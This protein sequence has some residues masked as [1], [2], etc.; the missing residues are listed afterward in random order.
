MQ[1]L[2]Y[3]REHK[4]LLESVRKGSPAK[5][6][7]YLGSSAVVNPL[8]QE[9][10]GALREAT[11]GDL[12]R[13]EGEELT[14]ESLVEQLES[15]SLFAKVKI[16]WVRE[17]NQA[18]KAL[19]RPIDQVW[20]DV[21]EG[22]FPSTILVVTASSLSPSSVL[23]KSVKGCGEVI[24]TGF[25]PKGSRRLPFVKSYIRESLARYGSSIEPGAVDLLLEFTGTG[26]LHSVNQEISKLAAMAEGGQVTS[27]MV[28]E[29]VIQ[30]RSEH[31]Y[32]LTSA[33]GA[34]DK[35]LP[36]VLSSLRRL[37]DQGLPPVVLLRTIANFLERVLVVKA[38]VELLEMEGVP[39]A[40]GFDLFK[41]RCLG[42]LKEILKEEGCETVIKE[43]KPYGIFKLA[44]A[45]DQ[46][47]QSVIM[48]AL[49]RLYKL[50]SGLKG[51]KTGP[52]LLLERFIV[53]LASNGAN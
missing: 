4:G 47:D 40:R 33:L 21:A 3:N 46:L 52:E 32:E 6:F 17:A 41:S 26:D 23:F 51:G 9:L 39:P 30:S 12:Y 31:L 34:G 19:K 53:S 27:Q 1:K 36:K 2:A 18:P 14:P 45:A 44:L 7:L 11:G 24:D 35:A 8:A 50:D 20:R 43:M 49:S 48:E 25:D 38:A 15:R 22:A 37:L 13:L 16:L 10:I 42:R 29:V 5:A 28:E